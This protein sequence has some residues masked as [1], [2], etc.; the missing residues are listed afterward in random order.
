MTD[1]REVL[2][3]YCARRDANVLL[4]CGCTVC[5]DCA[6]KPLVKLSIYE[7]AKWKEL[8]E[9]MEKANAE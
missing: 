3:P 6:G 2:C 8:A 7:H 9:I 1:K 5:S 4:K